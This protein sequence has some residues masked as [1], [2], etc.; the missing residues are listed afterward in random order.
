MSRI[1][2]NIASLAPESSQK[3]P[4][5]VPSTGTSETP[6]QNLTASR[7]NKETSPNHPT[8]EIIEKTGEGKAT[9]LEN[10]AES[11]KVES[12]QDGLKGL[13]ELLNFFIYQPQQGDMPK[14]RT[15]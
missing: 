6:G 8:R 14:G 1:K 15:K 7:L 12:Q 2:Q 13:E 11:Q 10:L 3:T 4:S 9:G 5:P